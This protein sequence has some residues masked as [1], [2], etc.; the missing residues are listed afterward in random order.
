MG[1]SVEAL[2]RKYRKKGLRLRCSTLERYEQLYEEQRGCCAICKDYHDV[3]ASDHD[4]HFMK[5]RGLLCIRCNLGLGFF[6]ENVA[7]LERAANYI[8]K[9]SRNPERVLPGEGLS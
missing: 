2:R 4:H 6:R 7:F 3:L 1:S 9:W 8:E 5:P